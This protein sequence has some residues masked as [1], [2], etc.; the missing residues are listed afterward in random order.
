M[1]VCMI[2][3]PADIIPDS[4]AVP[5]GRHLDSLAWYGGVAVWLCGSMVVWQYDNLTW[6]G[7]V[8]PTTSMVW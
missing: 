7:M 5:V 1:S 4:G 3:P 8:E 6:C 2:N